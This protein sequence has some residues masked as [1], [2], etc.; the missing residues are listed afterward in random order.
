M[1]QKNTLCSEEI[2]VIPMDLQ[3]ACMGIQ[4]QFSKKKKCCKK[5]KNGKSNCRSCPKL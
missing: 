4:C 3:Y 2:S 1:E 5:Y